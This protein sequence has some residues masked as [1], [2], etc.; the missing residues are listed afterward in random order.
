MRQALQMSLYIARHK[1]RK[2]CTTTYN[3]ESLDTKTCSEC[4]FCI[5]K[6][7]LHYW[8]WR[9]NVGGAVIKG[10]KGGSV[11][12]YWSSQSCR[13]M[14]KEGFIHLGSR[15]QIFLFFDIQDLM[16]RTGHLGATN[17]DREGEI[18]SAA[19]VVE[20]LTLNTGLSWNQVKGEKCRLWNVNK[21]VLVWCYRNSQSRI[22]IWIP[23][24][25]SAADLAGYA[26]DFQAWIFSVPGWLHQP[27][28]VDLWW[29]WRTPS[30][31]GTSLKPMAPIFSSE[32]EKP[33]R[34]PARR[35][36]DLFAS[37]HRHHTSVEIPNGKTERKL[38]CTQTSIGPG[39]RSISICNVIDTWSISMENTLNRNTIFKKY[40]CCRHQTGLLLLLCG[41]HFKTTKAKLSSILDRV[42]IKRTS[43]LSV[44]WRVSHCIRIVQMTFQQV[45]VHFHCLVLPS[46]PATTMRPRSKAAAKSALLVFKGTVSSDFSHVPERGNKVGMMQHNFILTRHSVLKQKGQML[47]LAFQ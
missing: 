6:S 31:G 26:F 21:T 4:S 33:R 40:V 34:C 11:V 37:R 29:R 16:S 24:L 5:P 17:G 2:V 7:I 27:R 43:P 15:L 39:D 9:L 30:I 12:P 20:A 41:L 36:H 38:R 25:R 10:Q 8:P 14:M 44:L 23:V 35:A 18:A 28:E 13:T 47:V 42:S 46:P 19:H 1:R 32:D 22:S 45:R 3:V